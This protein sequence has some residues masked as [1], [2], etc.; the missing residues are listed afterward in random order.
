M[1]GPL[2]IPYGSGEGIVIPED[3]M[4]WEFSRSGGPG[5]QHVNT[6]D[7]RARLR[8][9]LDGCT[10]LIPPVKERIRAARPSDITQDGELIITCDV[11]R[12]R[13]MNVE[14]ARQ[15]LIDLILRCLPPPKK[16][17]ATK[18]TRASQQRRLEGKSK[19][20]GVKAGRGKVRDD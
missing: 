12:S 20:S 13:G 19:R 2:V 7:T 9:D 4:R 15:R 8:F 18:P 3:R 14:E 16:R 5:G 6:T 17:Y 10:E 1:L 11:H